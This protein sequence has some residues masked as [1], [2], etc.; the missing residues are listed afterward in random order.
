MHTAV[1]SSAAFV[2]SATKTENAPSPHSAQCAQ[3]MAV[4]ACT[5]GATRTV[6]ISTAIH[7]SAAA[8]SAAIGTIAIL[9]CAIRR[10]PFA[11]NKIEPRPLAVAPRLAAAEP[12]RESVDGLPIAARKNAQ[13][14]PSKFVPNYPASL[15]AVLLEA[16]AKR[17]RT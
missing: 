2:T 1:T 15:Q 5:A 10:P 16:L 11:P 4:A 3:S 7:W 14:P 12:K 13:S 17:A 6:P 8:S 9:V